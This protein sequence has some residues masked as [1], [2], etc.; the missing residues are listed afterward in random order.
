VGSNF[1][2]RT[3]YE[4]DATYRLGSR[5]TI[6]PSAQYQ[7]LD[8]PGSSPR[9]TGDLTNETTYS[10][11]ITLNYKLTR[12][13]TLGLTGSEESRSSNFPGLSFD[14]TKVTLHTVATF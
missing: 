9:I 12:R 4:I 7:N 3:T 1:A 5:Y 10:G 13:I 2:L 8:Y 11:M 14:A 6:Q